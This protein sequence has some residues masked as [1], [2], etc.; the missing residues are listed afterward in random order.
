MLCQALVGG[1]ADT[2]GEKGVIGPT[3]GL[4]YSPRTV[5]A[6]DIGRGSDLETARSLAALRELNVAAEA[7]R[8]TAGIG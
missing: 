1:G 7:G 2:A 8:A 6:L 3:T 4:I 5:R